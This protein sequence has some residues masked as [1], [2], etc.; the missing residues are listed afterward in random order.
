MI[1][2]LLPNGTIKCLYNEQLDLASLGK[3][4]I[5]RASYVEFNNKK[6]RWEAK[7][8]SGKLIGIGKTRSK[9]VIAEIK[10]LESK[11]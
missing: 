2:D 7:L 3:L 8:P 9:A 1:I 4:K 5:K 10:Y 6:Q 11:M